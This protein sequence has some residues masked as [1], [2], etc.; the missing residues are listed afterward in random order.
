MLFRLPD[1]PVIVTFA[2]PT[3]AA[4]LA[5]SVKVLVPVVLLGLNV[6]VMP[7]GRPEAAKATL[8][9]N[10]FAG[11]TAMTVV[12]LPPCLT[13]IEIK[14][15][16]R[17]KL[18]VST[19]RLMAAV[20]FKLPDVP[21]TVMAAGPGETELPALRVRVLAPVVLPGLNVAV[22][23]AGRPE[24]VNITLPENPF[25]GVT[26][27]AVVTLAPGLMETE[28]GEAARVNSGCLAAPV[29]SLMKCWP[30]GVPHPVARSYPEVAENPLLPVVMS[31][32][33]SV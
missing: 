25:T 31:C 28:D 12:P 29:R 23:P 19:V 5:A 26:V 10:P 33:S 16:V 4:A 13:L 8:P 2:G 21:V 6:A 30:V 1:V 15:E 7:L 32:R 11:V 3:A 22:T 17:L 27:M 24:A 18:G 9:V 14:E 20:L